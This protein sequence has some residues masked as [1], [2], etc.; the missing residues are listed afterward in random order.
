MSAKRYLNN[1]CQSLAITLMGT[2][3]VSCTTIQEIRDAD[4]I[5]T[6]SLPGTPREIA[7]CFMEKTMGEW[8]VQ[9]WMND[10]GSIVKLQYSLGDQMFTHP[11]WEATLK[12]SPTGVDFQMR[13][14]LTVWGS[15]VDTVD[16]ALSLFRACAPST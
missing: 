3:L 5:H 7:F 2:L 1:F 16:K 14:R 6:S 13:A 15:P 11:L 9:N 12:R 4:P 8:Q 10:D